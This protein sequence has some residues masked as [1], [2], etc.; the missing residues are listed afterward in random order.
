M[1]ILRQVI[2]RFI[3]LTLLIS[4]LYGMESKLINIINYLQKLDL[5]TRIKKSRIVQEL[6]YFITFIQLVDFSIDL[7]V[8]LLT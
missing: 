4:V 1:E 7:C 8:S 6:T 3:L 2:K 5:F